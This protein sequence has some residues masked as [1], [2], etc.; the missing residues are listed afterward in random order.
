MALLL[1]SSV[2]VTSPT[3][4]ANPMVVFAEENTETPPEVEPQIIEKNESTIAENTDV[5]EDNQGTVET[6][7]CIIECNNGA[8][9]TNNAEVQDNKGVGVIESFEENNKDETAATGDGIKINSGTVE[10][11]NG[12]ILINQSEIVNNKEHV[13]SNEGD[14]VIIEN[15]GF[16]Y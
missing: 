4:L 7:N 10:E 13:F 9:V 8:I 16:V 15:N 14:G 5:I 6:N 11:N 3:L 12:D 2:M 1:M